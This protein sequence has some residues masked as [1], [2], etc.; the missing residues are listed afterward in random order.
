MS[1]TDHDLERGDLVIAIDAAGKAL[2][3]RALGGPVKGDNF[4][5]VWVCRE[6][7]WHAAQREGREPDGVPWPVE[8]VRPRV[9]ADAA[10]E[11]G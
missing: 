8:D 7:E 5:V 3:R 4:L 6:E 1:G 2:P 9:P 11:R 10:H